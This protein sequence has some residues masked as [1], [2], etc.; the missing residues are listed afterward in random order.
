MKWPALQ[1]CEANHDFPWTESWR[2]IGHR[3]DPEKHHWNPYPYVN[4]W[5]AALDAVAAHT[6]QEKQ[7]EKGMTSPVLKE[8][9][10][11]EKKKLLWEKAQ[12]KDMNE[13]GL[14]PCALSF[15][16]WFFTKQKLSWIGTYAVCFSF[17]LCCTHDRC[18]IGNSSAL[19][20]KP[21]TTVSPYWN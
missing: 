17:H 8:E 12:N 9:T 6:T 11:K 1:H 13:A 2:L 10:T 7:T 5:T 20:T 4:Q 14:D 19:N 21:E 16:L 18:N 15:L 3:E